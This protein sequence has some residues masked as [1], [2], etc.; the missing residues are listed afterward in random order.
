[1]EK[2]EKTKPKIDVCPRS[3]RDLGTPDE[4]DVSSRKSRK[5]PNYRVII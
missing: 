4:R 1:M 3:Y 2:R 5:I